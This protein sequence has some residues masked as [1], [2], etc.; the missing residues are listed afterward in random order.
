MKSLESRSNWWWRCFTMGFAA[1]CVL[2]LSSVAQAAEASSPRKTDAHS[3]EDATP[4]KVRVISIPLQDECSNDDNEAMD[5]MRAFVDPTTGELRA[6]TREE[7]AALARANAGKLRDR[8]NAASEVV[9][10]A[11]GSLIYYL[12]EDGMV[13]VVARTLSDGKA[14]FSCTPRAETHEALT[15]PLP[16]PKKDAVEKEKQ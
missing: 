6:P 9:V 8:T 13:D 10:G 15:R 16:A 4:V 3:G 7:E 12:G 11:D 5:G 2:V 1:A 14:V